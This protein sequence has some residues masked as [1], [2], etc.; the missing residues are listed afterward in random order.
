MC[1]MCSQH[2]PTY[3]LTA[4][5]SESPR[6]RISL[7]AALLSGRLSVDDRLQAHLEH[8]TGCRSCEA[9]CPSE[10]RFGEI[11]T[12]AKALLP[13]AA[14]PPKPPTITPIAGRGLRLYQ[15]SGL[16]KIVRA[17][18]IL[19]P[20]GLSEKESLLPEVPATPVWKNYYPAVT[21]TS[22]GDVALFT[23]CVANVFDRAALDASRRLLNAMGYGVHVPPSQGCCG[24][25][26]L[27][28][29][30]PKE[31][32]RLAAQ[33]LSA[34]ASLDIQAIVHTASG[35]TA[36]L[37]EYTQLLSNEQSE[38]FAAKIKDISHFIAEVSWP[39]ALQPR[40]LKKT[41]ALHTP[42]SLNNVLHQADAPRQL[43]EHIPTLKITPLPDTNRCCGGAGQYMLD[44]SEFA[45]QLRDKMLDGLDS[46]N[47]Q[48]EIDILAT[49]NL[50][51]SLHLAAGLRARGQQISVKHPIVILAQQLD[52]VS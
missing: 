30:H 27:H 25:I 32:A 19:N 7:I 8:C 3:Q 9:Y 46:I 33:N 10:V 21:D 52:L 12:E 44:Q 35:C 4:N 24:A 45:Q 16:Q 42:C 31:A 36:Q 28:G 2:C 51:C 23:G 13:H 41:I 18:G 22:R 37:S 43:L 15:Q 14:K 26:A 47:K 50:G 40:A 11:I 49:S 48:Y 29:G 6:G 38:S 5:E 39:T 34:F 17:S 1:G 20:L